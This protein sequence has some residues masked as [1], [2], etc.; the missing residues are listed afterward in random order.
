VAVVDGDEGDDVG[1]PV[2]GAAVV[3]GDGLEGDGMVEEVVPEPA[4]GVPSAEQP[5]TPRASP[6]ARTR[7]VAG[8]TL[9]GRPAT[10][11]ATMAAIITG[12]DGQPPRNAG[13][14]DAGQARGPGR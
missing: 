11:C 14:T 12:R 1:D 9:C 4:D 10:R 5:A 7:P 13:V 6:A 8:R 2:E 3:L